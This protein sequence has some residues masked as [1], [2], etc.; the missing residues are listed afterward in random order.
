MLECALPLRNRAESMA[1]LRRALGLNGQHLAR[2]IKDGSGGRLF[3]ARPLRVRQRTEGRRFFADADVTRNEVGLLQRDVEPGVVC[4]FK[5]K[6]LLHFPSRRGD[7]GQL[8]E[9]TDAVLEVD[10]QISFIQLAEINLGAFPTE[11]FG[12]LQAST[13]VGRV[14]PKQF[15]A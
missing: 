12:T 4:E 3:R 2:V 11:L 8:E 15:R 7:A 10:D 5:R 13:A 14:A 6:R 1:Q 9:T